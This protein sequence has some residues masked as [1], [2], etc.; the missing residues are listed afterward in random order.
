MR[1]LH[2]CC[3]FVCLW[4]SKPCNLSWKLSPVLSCGGKEPCPWLFTCEIQ[5]LC[6]LQSN[7]CEV[8][9]TK[10]ICLHLIWI[11]VWTAHIHKVQHHMRFNSVFILFFYIEKWILVIFN[12]ALLRREESS[13]PP[14]RLPP[15]S[16]LTC[17]PHHKGP[18]QAL[19]SAAAAKVGSEICN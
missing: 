3:C 13:N 16:Y 15:W 11:C 4:H 14:E 12:A 18:I 1:K 19:P 2:N 10:N 5:A 17:P 7:Y 6:K 9:L 8:F